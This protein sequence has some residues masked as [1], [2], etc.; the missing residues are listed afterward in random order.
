MDEKEKK[1][2]KTID[3]WINSGFYGIWQ[4]ESCDKIKDSEGE[5]RILVTLST[6]I[7]ETGKMA[8]NP[9][10]MVESVRVCC[11]YGYHYDRSTFVYSVDEA[12]INLYDRVRRQLKQAT[13]INVY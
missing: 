12:S 6:K 4:L 3:S 9:V 10:I 5:H 2:K 1:I 7:R 13:K 8:P 11:L